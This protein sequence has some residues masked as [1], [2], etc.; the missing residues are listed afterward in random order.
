MRRLP[1]VVPDQF[2][3]GQPAHAWTKPFDLADIDGRVQRLS[4]I[5]QDIDAVDRIFA[6]QRIDGDFADDAP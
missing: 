6:C 4:H 3:G 1:L 2:F 5:V